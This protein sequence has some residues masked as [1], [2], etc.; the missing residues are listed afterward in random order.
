MKRKVVGVLTFIIALVTMLAGVGIPAYA[1][2]VDITPTRVTAEWVKNGDNQ[3]I[4]ADGNLHFTPYALYE[5]NQNTAVKALYSFSLSAQNG[6]EAPA[7]SIH[8]K[9][10][11][12][13]I[14]QGSYTKDGWG[15]VT[16][17][18]AVLSIPN[19]GSGVSKDGFC[20]SVL[21]DD[22]DYIEITNDRA[23][24]ASGSYS[25]VLLR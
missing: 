2:D 6:V 3:E 20:T 7:N 1:A 5:D 19:C 22:K 11:R 13:V 18:N 16:N 17:N 12:N 15:F 9:I 14:G 10:P 4:D 25:L 24:N 8:L 21:S 23:V